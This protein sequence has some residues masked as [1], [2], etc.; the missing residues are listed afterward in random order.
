MLATRVLG[1]R[2]LGIRLLRQGLRGERGVRLHGSRRAGRKSRIGLRRR[3]G[4]MDKFKAMGG[5]RAV[6]L[7]GLGMP[8]LMR[9]MRPSRATLLLARLGLFIALRRM[10]VGLVR[11]GFILVRR[12]RD[13]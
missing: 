4:R 12:R 10:P 13:I 8:I 3:L 1:T 11:D 9:G 6:S 5:C 2:V 7:S